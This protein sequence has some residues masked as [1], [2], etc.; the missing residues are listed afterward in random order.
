M[1]KLLLVLLQVWLLT[2]ATGQTGNLDPSFGT[3][4]I[5]VIWEPLDLSGF[6][7]LKTFPDDDGGNI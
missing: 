3:K 5:K 1:K 2:T 7:L 6:T 4:G